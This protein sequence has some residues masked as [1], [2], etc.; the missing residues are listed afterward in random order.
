VFGGGGG[1]GGG[2]VVQEKE[3]FTT[4]LK[5][6]S[7][8]PKILG[9]NLLRREQSSD[10]YLGRKIF[11]GK[12]GGLTVIE[13]FLGEETKKTKMGTGKKG[14]GKGWGY[15]ERELVFGEFP[16]KDI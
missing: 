6:S 4:E 10:F 8:I 5:V 15:K 1:G 16:G 13:V 9:I 7:P 12:R 2:G 3:A 14:T 11:W